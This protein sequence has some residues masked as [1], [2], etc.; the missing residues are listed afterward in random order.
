MAE[1]GGHRPSDPPPKFDFDAYLDF[2]ER[3]GHNFA[4][5][6]TWELTTWDTRSSAAAWR[7]KVPHYAAPHPWPRT[8][9]G[10]ALD[11]KPKFD[12]AKHNPEYFQR[13][14]ARVK[15]AG[16]R[17]IYVSVML[18]EGW[19]LQFAPKAWESHPFHPANNV[20]GINGD[21]NG[22]GKGLEVHELANPK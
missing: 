2:L 19:G 21:T 14:R 8:G 11:G 10:K 5:L 17:G 22:D 12:L 4:R 15:A 3:H 13:L 18:F 20:N 1:P 9:R 7:K 6:W 16:Q